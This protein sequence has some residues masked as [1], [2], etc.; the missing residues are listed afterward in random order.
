[1]LK[2]NQK[3]FNILLKFRVHRVAVIADIE[4]AFLMVSVAKKDRDVLHFLWVDDILADQPKITELRFARVVLG[5]SSSPFLLNA[6]LRHHLER[7]QDSHPDLVKNLCGSFYVDDLVTG[8]EDEEQAYQLFT[9]SREILKDGGFNLRKFQ[10]N[11]SML[12][13]RVQQETKSQEGQSYTVSSE[14][15]RSSSCGHM[16]MS[17]EESYSSSVLGTGQ[18]MHSGE[19]KV[20]GVRWNVSSD[21]IVLNLDEVA[22]ISLTLEIFDPLGFL[23][24]VVIRFKI[25]FQE[26]CE[27]KLEWDQPLSGQL[28]RKWITL[29][30]SLQDSISISI[31]RCYYA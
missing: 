6:T 26:L 14:E 21:Q 3:I 11:S 25:F 31:P 5:L 9:T 4:K 20:L 29:G 12:Q 27:A 19:L 8:A 7:Y 30:S 18:E 23:S 16:V 2:L 1:M 22:S 24:L 17:S 15:S 13:S 10:S 28:L